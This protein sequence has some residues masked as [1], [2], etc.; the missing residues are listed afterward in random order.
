MSHN[1]RNA[2]LLLLL[3]SAIW[4]FA[5]VAQRVGM[6]HVGPLTFNA[7]RFA[8]GA[9]ALAP[10][11]RIR[12]GR[13]AVLNETPRPSSGARAWTPLKA[14]LAT[15]LLLFGGSTLQQIGVVYTTAG[16]A[17][18]ITSLYVVFVPLLGLFWGQRTGRWTWLGAVAA[19]AGLYLLSARGV[20]SIALGDGLVLLGAIFWAGHVLLV[21]HLVGCQPALRL[22]ISQFAVCSVLSLFGA[23]V[24]E[25]MA[26]PAIR[27]A[28]VPILYA[29]L[30]SVAVAY[31]LQV[32]GQRHARPAPAAIILSFEAV[33]AAVGGWIILGETMSLRGLA[34]AALM[35]AGVVLAQMDGTGQEK[36]PGI[37]PDK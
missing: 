29:G 23:L 11:L 12:S 28:A 37:V 3:A 14:G 22:A 16:K 33:F 34:G 31:T 5:F 19:A 25:S 9:V 20:W 1:R 15:G 32:I 10:L 8:L 26:W 17:G 24:F 21:G 4:G 36:G 2:H 7:V 35:L 30:L 27:A 13:F 18:F 6:R